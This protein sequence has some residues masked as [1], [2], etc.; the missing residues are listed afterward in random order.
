MRQSGEFFARNAFNDEPVTIALAAKSGHRHSSARKRDLD[1]I[2][3]SQ[4][5]VT[6]DFSMLLVCHH[7]NSN[8]VKNERVNPL[9]IKLTEFAK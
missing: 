7:T 8:G 1:R 3:K 4:G 2:C 9:P 5:C 6:R